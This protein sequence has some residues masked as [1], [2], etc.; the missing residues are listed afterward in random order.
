MEMSIYTFTHDYYLLEL[1]AL[2][3]AAFYNSFPLYRNKLNYKGEQIKLAP[4]VRIYG[5]NEFN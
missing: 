5:T 4:V 1:P 3:R 2:D